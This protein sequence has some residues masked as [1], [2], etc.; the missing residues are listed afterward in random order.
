MF[1]VAMVNVP[2][3]SGD[4]AYRGRIIRSYIPLSALH[5]HCTTAPFEH[6][7]PL[8]GCNQCLP[9]FQILRRNRLCHRYGMRKLLPSYIRGHILWWARNPMTVCAVG[10]LTCSHVLSTK[11]AAGTTRPIYRCP[12]VVLGPIVLIH[13]MIRGQWTRLPVGISV[14]DA[15]SANMCRGYF[16]HIMGPMT[17]V[18]L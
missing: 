8:P 6:L 2:G 4:A 12:A 16:W 10:R 18:C 13:R 11:M 1:A 5:L 15:L 17:H 7:Q 9:V 14:R 3:M